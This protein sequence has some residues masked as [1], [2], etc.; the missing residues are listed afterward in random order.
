MPPASTCVTACDLASFRKNRNG[1]QLLWRHA[2]A[3][4]IQALT[5]GGGCLSWGAHPGL[6]AP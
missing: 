6:S 4:L 2:W 5:V 1:E 3:L